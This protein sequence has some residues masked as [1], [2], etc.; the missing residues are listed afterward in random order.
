MAIT[1]KQKH[2]L[3]GLA[4]KLK[5]VVLTGDAGITDAIIDKIVVELERH[6][7]IKVRVADGPQTARDI[8][9]SL[10]ERT[11]SQLVQVIG[12]VVILYRARKKEPVIVLPK[13]VK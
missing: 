2:H 7:L 4:H 9:P 3:R 8:G 10:A 5:P 13:A 11:T 12:K 6:E 1:G